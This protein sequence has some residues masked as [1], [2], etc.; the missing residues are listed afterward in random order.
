MT[1]APPR[2]LR[3]IVEYDGA[4]LGGWQRQ[5][6]APTVQGHLEEAAARILQHPVTVTGASRTD[7]GVHAVG[8]VASL[9]TH[10]PIAAHGL[11]RGL[12]SLLPPAIAVTDVR[13]VDD[14]FHPRFSAT[15][16]AYRYLV[17]A[18]P[19]RAPRWARW[20]WHRP[21]PLDAAAM[22]A[23]AAAFVGEHDFKGFRATSCTARTTV[24]RI[25]RV[26]V[27]SP[28]PALLALDV[29]GNAFLHNMVRIIAG[30][31]V[32][33][34]R[35][36]LDPASMAAVIASGDRTQA[37]PTAPAHGLTLVEVRYDG[38]RPRPRPAV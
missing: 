23:A 8:Q 14:D 27:T 16:K 24:R 7:A 25:D 28:E 18:R 11:R 9:R 13:E 37:G 19:D 36:R 26:T 33:V 31:L 10:R 35:G 29:S 4:D 1:E 21:Q 30:T 5:D 2:Q 3:L 6:N 17:L 32:E 15:G 22:A 34:G 12:N 20:A 38:A